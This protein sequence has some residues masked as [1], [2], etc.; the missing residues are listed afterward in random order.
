[1]QTF[2]VVVAWTVLILFA[3]GLIWLLVIII[4]GVGDSIH[5]WKVDYDA[6][7]RFYAQHCKVTAT[8]ESS[9]SYGFAGG[10][11]VYLSTSGT[12]TYTCNDGTTHTVEE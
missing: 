9:G 11:Y 6:Q 2:K 3:A 12:K 10:K 8:T 5:A 7:Q 1:M 4:H